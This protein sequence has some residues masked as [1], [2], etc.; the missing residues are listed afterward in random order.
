MHAPLV[1]GWGPG[2]SY[3]DTDRRTAGEHGTW[4]PVPDWGP[5]A[6]RYVACELWVQILSLAVSPAGQGPRPALCRSTSERTCT[7]SQ[8]AESRTADLPRRWRVACSP[9]PAA[10]A[11]IVRG[12]GPEFGRQRLAPYGSQPLVCRGGL[13]GARSEVLG[14]LK[15]PGRM[16]S[17]AESKACDECSAP[18][19]SHLPGHCNRPQDL[20]LS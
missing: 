15:R 18:A 2:S 8:A 9:W 12:S 6:V 7:T 17:S 10:R 1:P 16:T 14:D 5:G 11:R 13:R 3:E 19:G 4:R 20:V